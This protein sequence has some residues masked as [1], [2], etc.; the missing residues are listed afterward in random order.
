MK[1]S[2]SLIVVL[3]N[4]QVRINTLFL[5][6]KSNNNIN[7]TNNLNTQS[8]TYTNTVGSAT[9]YSENFSRDS[10]TFS[11]VNL[12]PTFLPN[13]DNVIYIYNIG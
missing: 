13:I 9:N 7:L 4:F 8:S 3:L 11:A 12:E 1:I 2:Y 6:I 10:Y 5:K